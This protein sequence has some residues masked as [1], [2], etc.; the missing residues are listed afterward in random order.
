[1]PAVRA[2][3]LGSVHVE[4]RLSAF[5]RRYGRM[6]DQP[7]AP[8]MGECFLAVVVEVLLTEKQKP[9]FQDSLMDG[10]NSF[11]LQVRSEADAAHLSAEDAA[12]G[13]YVESA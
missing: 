3:A 4:D 5:E 11:R 13:F 10:A 9:V 8:Q 1:M 7:L 12:D 2:A 6:R